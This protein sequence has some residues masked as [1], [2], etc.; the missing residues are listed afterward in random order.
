MRANFALMKKLSEKTRVAPKLRI[1]KLLQ[2]NV[3][4]AT[5][6]KVVEDLQQW[7]FKLDKNLVDV[8]GRVLPAEKIKFGNKILVTP[9]NADWNF[10]MQEKPTFHVHH[11]LKDWTVLVPSSVKQQAL[12]YIILFFLLLS[13]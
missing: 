11:E 5:H 13:G 2:F 12:V 6:K 8:P 9:K 3:K 10:D 7:N 4:L 1:E